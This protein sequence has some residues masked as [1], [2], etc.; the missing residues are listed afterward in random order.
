MAHTIL[1][2]ASPPRRHLRP[3]ALPR[4]HTRVSSRGTTDSTTV[5]CTGAGGQIVTFDLTA[6]APL[7]FSQT[8]HR[9]AMAKILISRAL[10]SGA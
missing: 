2:R 6:I 5:F 1:G 9:C 4:E 7:F 3:E 10:Q 8:S